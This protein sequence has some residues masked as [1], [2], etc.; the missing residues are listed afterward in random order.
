MAD[1]IKLRA[2]A[3][4]NLFLEITGKRDDGYHLLRSVMQSVS[5]F[6]TLEFSLSDG[7]GIEIITDAKGVPL[8][9]KNLI[10]KAIDAFYVRAEDVKRKKVSIKLKKKIPTMAGMAGGSSDAAATLVALNELYD[11]PFT[12]SQ[13]C[14]IG[15]RLGADVPFC[16]KGGTILCEGV[17]EKLSALEPL[18]DCCFVVVK[19][20]LSIST[21]EAY[22]KFDNMVIDRQPDYPSFA[23]GLKNNN[24]NLMSGAI[25]N[26][27][28]YACA[29]K[30]INDIKYK[31]VENGAKN[32]MM[33]GS[34][35]AVFGIF[36]NIK[37]AK[38]AVKIFGE[39]PFC[40]VLLPVNTGVEIVS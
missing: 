16:I 27:L 37:T 18:K 6:D 24:L 5:L 25:Y 35:S 17:G 21:P 15:A 10:W 33:T 26:S 19:P 31:L 28:E 11:K 34:G 36:D 38:N 7:E 22:K 39:Y 1:K 40:D 20:D 13:I 2:Y 29:L 23:E 32:S 3:K 4:L 30:E 14:D 9:K 8:D 12:T